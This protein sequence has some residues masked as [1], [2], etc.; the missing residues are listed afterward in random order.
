MRFIG[1]TLC[2][3]ASSLGAR[4]E[5]VEERVT[6]LEAR[7]K[8][9]EQ[10]LQKAAAPVAGGE[11]EGTY[12]AVLPDGKVIALELKGGK[13][14]AKLGDDTKAGTYDVVGQTLI[15]TVDGHAETLNIDG[16]HLR[17]AKADDKVDFIKSK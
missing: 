14:V 1:L 7:V 11:I 17:A 16:E 12:K 3:L 15:V 2:L 6:A 9:L 10:A 5:S 13:A 8:V 4:A